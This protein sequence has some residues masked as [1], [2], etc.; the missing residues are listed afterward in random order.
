MKN[1]TRFR[2]PTWRGQTL[3]EFALVIPIVLLLLLGFFDL[4]RALINYSALT[5]A[6]REGA[7]SGIVMAY[8]EAAIKDKV[9]EYAFTLTNNSVPLTA[10]DI[11]ANA[12]VNSDG[13]LETL[14]VTGTYCFLPITP[15]IAAIVGNNC[16][17]GGRGINL[18]ATS[19]M[20]YEPGFR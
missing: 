9:L 20:H 6:V 4:G 5:N 8:N 1:Q 7:R 15:G 12:S 18:T 17:G 2:T 16:T 3:V 14:E 19:I 10:D 11:I 13:F